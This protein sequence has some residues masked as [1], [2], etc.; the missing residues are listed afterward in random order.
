MRKSDNIEVRQIRSNIQIIEI[1]EENQI[2]GIKKIL[3]RILQ[4]YVSL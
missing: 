2:K 3:K 1:P 4:Q